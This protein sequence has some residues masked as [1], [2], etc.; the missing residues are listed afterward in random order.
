MTV[1]TPPAEV[2]IDVE[3]VRALLQEQ[4]IDTRDRSVAELD[5]GW[6]NALY[7]VE[8]GSHPQPELRQRLIVRLPRR[9][10]AVELLRHEQRWLP[11][12]F[13]DSPL[14]LPRPLLLGRPGHGYPWPFSVVP[15]L[16]GVASDLEPPDADQATVYADFL[17]TVHQ[18][19][20]SDAPVNPYRGVP[21]STRNQGFLE[22][23]QR[24][25]TELPETHL[26]LLDI[27]DAAVNLP[28]DMA[29]TWL[30]GDPHARNLLVEQGKISG[31]IDW[32][33]MCAGDRANDLGAIWMHFHELEAR[34]VAINH[35]QS[36]CPGVSANTWVRAR[37][38][39]LLFGVILFDSGR[40]DHPRHRRMGQRTLNNLLGDLRAGQFG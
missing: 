36:R 16:A 1:G 13:L 6:D 7:S 24:C 20:P 5:S 27:W 15:F 11:Q 12:L 30:H 37:G 40:E 29:P 34:N 21:L 2:E 3:L 38:W 31:V 25:A 35:Y 8:P 33:D 14:P 9:K 23:W 18:P 39:A 10:V 19:A 22:R 26:Q 4:G 28:I 32:G 17:A